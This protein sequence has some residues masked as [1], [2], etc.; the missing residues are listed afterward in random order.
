MKRRD[1]FATTALGGSAVYLTGCEGLD[2][3]ARSEGTGIQIIG[4]IVILARYKASQS[5]QNVAQVRAAK[6]YVE[7]AVKPAYKKQEVALKK[8]ESTAQATAKKRVDTVRKSY[9][10]K[11]A[12]VRNDPAKTQAVTAEREQVVARE[13]AEATK[14]VEEATKELR[15]LGNTYA[16]VSQGVDFAVRRNDASQAVNEFSRFRNSGLMVAA[17]GYA[18]S[19]LAVAV[20]RQNVP[21]EAKG[22]ETLMV[23]DTKRQALASDDVLV[24]DRRPA[25]GAQAKLDGRSVTFAGEG[26]F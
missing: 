14:S 7:V 6:A 15:E 19:Y 11:I 20:P 4:A 17:A 16:M 22:A 23:W 24:V 1:F 10:K 12:A 2:Y 21:A 8:K 5:Q 3:S 13:T 9:E 25:T 26:N 18:P